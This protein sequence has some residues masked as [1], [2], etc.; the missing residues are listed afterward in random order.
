MRR[1]ELEIGPVH[2]VSHSTDRDALQ[3]ILS[4]KSR[5]YRKTG[6]RDLFALKWGRVLIERIHAAQSGGFAGM[7]SLLYAGDKLLA[8]HLG[9]RSRTVWHYWFPAYDPQFA[10]YSPGLLLLLKMA[11]HAP[12]I[13]LRTIDLG[14]G[15]TL[16]KRRLMNASVSVAEGS[17]E[18]P[19]WL[20][21]VRGMR[22]KAK[23]LV[24]SNLL[25]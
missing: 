19:S 2:F 20:S 22:R 5:Q 10:K 15:M 21:L 3:Q 14:T 4:W 8:G 6:W 23:R 17:V 25:S 11:E 13:G 18:R 1:L 12:K 7:L 24:Q 16:Y 9:M